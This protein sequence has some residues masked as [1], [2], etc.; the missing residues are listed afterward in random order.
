LC[1]TPG[2]P[3]I[4][5]VRLILANMAPPHNTALDTSNQHLQTIPAGRTTAT[6][7]G[8]TDNYEAAG[9]GTV[10]FGNL[11]LPDVGFGTYGGTQF[12]DTLVNHDAGK[13]IQMF[14]ADSQGNIFTNPTNGAM[15]SNM[16]YMALGKQLDWHTFYPSETVVLSVLM[17]HNIAGN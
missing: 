1:S 15:T 14:W 2:P 7:T 9:G 13:A 5:A 8:V 6:Y 17:G 16:P 12:K 3:V 4:G 11:F 10:G